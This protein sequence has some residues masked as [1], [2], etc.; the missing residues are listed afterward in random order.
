MG[1][2]ILGLPLTNARRKHLFHIVYKSFI[3]MNLYETT[4][5]DE[6]TIQQQRIN[7]RIYVILLISCLSIILFSMAMI[8]RSITKIHMRP[9]IEDY[10]HLLSLDLNDLNCPCTF[11]SIPYNDFVTELYVNEFHEACSRDVITYVLLTGNSDC[12]LICAW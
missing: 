5:T 4:T 6:R 1:I 9:S 10:E 12:N 7:T 2:I 11:I 3:N 8:E